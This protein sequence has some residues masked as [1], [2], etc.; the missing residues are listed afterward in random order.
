VGVE[1]KMSSSRE[2]EP[3][4][5]TSQT[6]TSQRPRSS[7]AFCLSVFIVGCIGLSVAIAWSYR[8]S[9]PSPEPV[10]PETTTS[11]SGTASLE[12]VGP[13]NA[14]SLLLDTVPL[15]IFSLM[16]WGSPGSFGTED[17]ELR[18]KAI[19]EYIGNHTEYDIFLLND[20]WMRGDHEKIKTLIPEGYQM[21]G[22]GELAARSCDGLAAPEFCSG[23][24]IISKYP[25]KDIEFSPYTDHGDFFWDY[26][27]FLRR[28][29]GRVQIEP[30]PGHTVDVFV[31]SLASIDYNY[32]YRESQAKELLSIVAKSDADHIIVAGDFNVDPRDNEDTYKTLK[33]ELT[34][35]VE[36]FYKNDP[37]KYLDPKLSTFGNAHNTYSS[38]GQHPV[39]YD[40]IWCKPNNGNGITVADFQ[41]PILRT[42]RE[43]ISFSDHEAVTA[44][45]QLSK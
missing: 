27:Y 41:V 38:K 37:A 26:E 32:W 21:S 1:S 23:L 5:P 18:V 35:A 9:L 43:E 20:L 17:K 30:S 12:M 6:S 22:V 44:K 24:A 39:V 19:G 29:A 8:E 4:L 25:F 16:V 36:E 3:L 2:T 11:S 10:P 45:F 42:K 40:Y 14:S 28:G 33:S 31:T 13:A 34:D 7:Y 15:N